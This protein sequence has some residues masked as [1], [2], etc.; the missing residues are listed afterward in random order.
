MSTEPLP[1][2]LP[3]P[4]PETQAP[5]PAAAPK[6]VH[7]TGFSAAP[8]PG[9]PRPGGKPIPEKWQR[10]GPQR[11]DKPPQDN[12][13]NPPQNAVR[14]FDSYK[15]NK[16]DLDKDI[17]AELNAAMSAM[18]ELPPLDS[19]E[20]PTEK[21]V[22][23][24][25]KGRVLSIHGKDVFLDVPG[26]RSQG[27]LAIQE[28]E[29]KYPNIGDEVEFMIER[30]DSANGLLVLTLG[31]AV[32]AVT[33]WSGISLGMIVEARVTDVNKNKTGLMVEVNGIKAFMPISQAD[34]Y[35]VEQPEQFI[36]QKLKCVVIE[37]DIH[38]RNLIVSRRA[39]L[40]R[41]RKMKE[42]EFWSKLEE[43]QVRKGIVKTIKAF[44]A[45]VDLGGA[46]GLIPI[47]ELSW[48]RVGTAEEVVKVG[49]EVEVKIARLDRDAR[50]IGLSLRAMQGNPWDDFARDHRPG[51]RIEGKVT[52]IADFGAFVELAPG[53][54][55]L[56]HISELT[57]GRV[58]KV[59][60]AVSEGQMVTVQI[61]NIDTEQRRIGLSLKAIAA[62]AE[63]AADESETKEEQ[64]DRE[65][66]AALMAARK[67]SL[68]L[69]GGVGGTPFKFERQ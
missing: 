41:E 64:A 40:E 62:E 46:D 13:K 58:R 26:G 27:V 9:A 3:A 61:V 28:F 36:G 2:T 60:D 22:G 42:E 23:G 63:Q 35:R 44:G 5:V 11:G 66:A 32:Q 53:I 45:F 17:E 52:R 47:S 48:T 50:K 15:P 43:G 68:N 56:I 65:E 55:G 54:E 8:K 16:R 24:R 51:V 6:P 25:K 1:E 59:S 18:A 21:A 14:D 12:A 49:Q 10:G 29:G 57:T 34:L 37:V 19:P 38:D 69:R 39:L 7:T 20:N 4:T 31:G 30:Y 67:P 33:D